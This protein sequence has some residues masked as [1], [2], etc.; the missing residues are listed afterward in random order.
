M[1]PETLH[2]VLAATQNSNV[3]TGEVGRKAIG[4]TAYGFKTMVLA[5]TG[6]Q[7]PGGLGPCLETFLVV[8]ME[9][10][11]LLAYWGGGQGFC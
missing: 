6:I 4:C 10:G 1:G 11:M 5:R 7:S 9:E 3:L 2:V 8:T